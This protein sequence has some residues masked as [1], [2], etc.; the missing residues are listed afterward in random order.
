MGIRH[1]S[2]DMWKV[3]NAHP[4]GHKFEMRHRDDQG[5]VDQYNVYLTRKEALIVAK[6]AG[7]IRTLA[8][9][10]DELY[11]EDLY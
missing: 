11:S 2:L 4:E 3:I 1:Y 5:F 10:V 8:P 9:L 6:A 7:Q